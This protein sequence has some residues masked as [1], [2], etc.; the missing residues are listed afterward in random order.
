MATA[1][2]MATA[3]Q[4]NAGTATIAATAAAAGRVRT[5]RI[6]R[7]RMLRRYTAARSALLAARA[8]ATGPSTFQPHISTV[9]AKV[10]IACPEMT[11]EI[12]SPPTKPEMTGRSSSGVIKDSRGRTVNP[13]SRSS[14]V[15]I[16]AGILVS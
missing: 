14:T 1:Q 7:V 3:S 10:P 8:T 9:A 13:E 4:R 12:P 16:R 15:L 6:S 2:A 5:S 11:L